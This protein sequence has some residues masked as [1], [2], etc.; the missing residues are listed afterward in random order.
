MVKIINENY[1]NVLPDHSKELIKL[2]TDLTMSDK[3]WCLQ[4]IEEGENLQRE[5][6]RAKLHKSL[7][8][9]QDIAIASLKRD[10]CSL[11]FVHKMLLKNKQVAL[12]AM[13]SS[14]W[15]LVSALPGTVFFYEKDRDVLLTAV[16]RQSRKV[17][18][19]AHPSLRDDKKLMREVDSIP[20]G[21]LGEESFSCVN[22][23]E[24]V[25]DCYHEGLY[26]YGNFREYALLKKTTMAWILLNL[27]GIS[28][29]E[30]KIEKFKTACKSSFLSG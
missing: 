16:K 26:Y 22:D 20:Y 23:N 2:F 27:E 21:D 19:Y 5:E 25:G 8:K 4:F 1:K 12:A 6:F 24:W 14:V 11:S 17:L 3:E 10:C 30:D 7:L 9:D 15:D 18:H 29:N 13:Q 28:A